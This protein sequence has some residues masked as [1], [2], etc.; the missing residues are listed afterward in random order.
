MNIKKTSE[1]VCLVYSIL[2]DVI[3]YEEKKKEKTLKNTS[4]GVQH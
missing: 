2:N 1:K 4:E 3:H